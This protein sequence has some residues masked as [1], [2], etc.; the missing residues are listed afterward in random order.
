MWV[1][2]RWLHTI[3]KKFSTVWVPVVI[4]VLGSIGFCTFLRPPNGSYSDVAQ[5]P[6]IDGNLTFHKYF[7]LRE[8]GLLFAL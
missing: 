3:I 1:E 4:Q 5:S 7:S 6:L 8:I 2:L